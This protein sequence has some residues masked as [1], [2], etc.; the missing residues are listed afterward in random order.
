VSQ[1]DE[2]ER[3]W[4]KLIGQASVIL[5]GVSDAEL[6]VQLFDVL[7]EF[8]DGSN[9]WLETIDFTVVP[10]S[11]EYP[12][13]PLTGRALRLYG[14]VD[15]NNV[16]QNAVMSDIGIV[17]FLFPVSVPQQMKATVVKTVTDPFQC[18]PPH[19]PEW[20]LP[21]HGLGLL[22]GVL[23]TMMMQPGQSYS[24]QQMG[25]FYQGKFRNAIAHARVATMK[26]NTVGAQAWAYPQAFSVRGQR[27]GVSTFNVHPVSK[28]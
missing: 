6:R 13:Y 15:Q 20:V 21:V 17:Q 5:A 19:I 10:D 3:Y 11:L 9:C 23:G 1:S 28:R 16:P 8:F 26:A 27:G 24:N 4:A 7:Q 22:H 2:V 25:A 18:F 14:V 12:L